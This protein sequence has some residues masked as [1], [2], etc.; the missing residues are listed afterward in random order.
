MGDANSCVRRRA[1]YLT[2]EIF[3]AEDGDLPNNVQQFVNQVR[4]ERV[5]SYREMQALSHTIRRLT[6]SDFHGIQDFKLPDS[7]A[8]RPV[9]AE[10]ERGVLPS[11]DGR[12]AWAFFHR[13]GEEGAKTPV[14]PPSFASTQGSMPRL[15]VLGLDQGSKG[16]AACAF[17]ILFLGLICYVRWDKFHRLIRDLKLTLEHSCGGLF[18]KTQLYTSYIWSVN[19]KPL[20]ALGNYGTVKKDILHA[21]LSPARNTIQSERFRK[22]GPRIVS[23]FNEKP[24]AG[25]ASTRPCDN[26]GFQIDHAL[27]MGQNLSFDTIA[28][29]QQLFDNLP[30]IA[31]SFVNVLSMSKLGRWFSWQDCAHEQL[32]EFFASK[33]LLEDHVVDARVLRLG[34]RR[35]VRNVGSCLD[36]WKSPR[37]RSPLV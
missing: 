19:Y 28:D 20:P 9:R 5:A 36:R 23:S 2:A 25:S 17:G 22:Y 1:A 32:P 34:R 12:T 27:K 29:Q 8:L 13:E 3:A 11:A 15:L 26:A 33:M 31:R 14:L 4:R 37:R 6:K 10:E 16:A 21:F 7:V 30:A 24:P 35:P 18:L